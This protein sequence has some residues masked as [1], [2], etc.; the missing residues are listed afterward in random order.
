M[1]KVLN[2]IS[3]IASCYN[4]NKVVLFGSRA[5]G[6]NTPKSD[7]DIA[8]FSD[9]MDVSEKNAFYKDIDNIKTLN[10]I[11]VVFIKERH[12]GTELYQ[13]I[14]ND[15]VTIMNKFQIKLDNYRNALARLH[16]AIEEEQSTQSLAVRDGAIKR[17]EFTAELA[18]KTIREY[19]LSEGVSDINSPKKVMREAFNNDIVKDD[20]GW[21][22]ILDDRNSTAHIYDD[23]DAAEVYGRIIS[24]H[25]MLFDELAGELSQNRGC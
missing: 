22:Q 12:K 20:E 4:I 18:W 13:N 10:K 9:D 5:R 17:F 1:D 3:R 6:D 8:V 16:E 7:Y 23:E 21:I 2:E 25:I 24:K 19:L 15:G 11:D 14:K